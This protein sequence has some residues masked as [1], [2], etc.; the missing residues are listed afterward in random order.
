MPRPRHGWA[1]W[2]AAGAVT[3]SAGIRGKV[4]GVTVVVDADVGITPRTFSKERFVTPGRSASLK[5]R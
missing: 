3:A 5:P 4:V 2:S 1:N